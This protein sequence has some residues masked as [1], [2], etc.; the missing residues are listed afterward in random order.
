MT[1]S[2]R[3][4]GSVIDTPAS[5]ERESGCSQTEQKGP[6]RLRK[7]LLSTY[8]LLPS[9]ILRPCSA[10]DSGHEEG[11]A[12]DWMV[13]VRD[14]EQKATGD[15]F[16]TWLQATDSFGNPAAMARR[17]GISYVIW[18]NQMWRPSTGLWTDYNSC[19][20]PRK[21]FRSLD[22]TCHRDHVHVS[23]SWDGAMGRTSFY[24]GFVA[25]PAPLADAWVPALAT[26]AP[27]VVPVVAT[28]V[29]STRLGVGLP[30]G[31]CRV[32]PDVRLDVP[33]LG[34]GPVPADGVASVNLRVG[35]SRPDAAA[36]LRVW[37]A[38]TAAPLVPLV[39]TDKGTSAVAELSVPVGPHGLV[40]L[41][42][43]GGMGHLVVDVT[44]YS[45][46]SVL[47]PA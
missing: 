17:L 25:C 11:R 20:K 9:N 13:S 21:R 3:T 41:A 10:A 42:L 1:P 45:G 2:T 46:Y 40:S 15:A 22:T 47:P 36:E 16:L 30:D 26:A 19:T 12:L 37:T 14:P 33:V 18:N 32:H 5:W 35:L 23:F 44:G 7:L 29:L 39:V 6:R 28:R 24:S 27:E 43:T 31:P 34:I 8:G 38:G 4:F